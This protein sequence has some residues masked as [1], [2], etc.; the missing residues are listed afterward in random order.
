MDTDRQVE[1][2][3]ATAISFF[4][5]C[6]LLITCSNNKSTGQQM[7]NLLSAAN[8]I[9]ASANSFSRAPP[10]LTTEL[11]TPSGSSATGAADGRRQEIF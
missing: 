4:A 6:Q 8:S 10:T 1:L 2:I 11:T 3:L 9:Q 7:S 5:C